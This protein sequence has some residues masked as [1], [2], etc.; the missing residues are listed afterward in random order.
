VVIHLNRVSL[1]AQANS[2]F[3]PVKRPL[4]SLADELNVKATAAL[5][6]AR[7]MPPGVRRAKAMNKAMILRNAVEMHEHFLGKGDAPAR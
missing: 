4:A 2:S 1:S 3:V 6:A 7:D 5:V